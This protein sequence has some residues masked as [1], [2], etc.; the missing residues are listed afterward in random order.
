MTTEKHQEGQID[1]MNAKASGIIC[2]PMMDHVGRAKMEALQ[3][4][5]LIDYLKGWNEG[6]HRANVIEMIAFGRKVAEQ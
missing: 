6:W 5:P 3:G 2:S 1:G 4:E